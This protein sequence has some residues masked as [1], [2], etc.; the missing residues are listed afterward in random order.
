MPKITVYTMAHCPYCERAKSLL[1]SKNLPFDEVKVPLDDDAG[2][3]DLYR[4]SGM[5][6]MP[7]IFADDRLIG[8]Y[9]ELAQLD[10]QDGLASLK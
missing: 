8:G 9:A 6:T 2:W 5:R 1:K 7:Q 10:A 3:D 4:K